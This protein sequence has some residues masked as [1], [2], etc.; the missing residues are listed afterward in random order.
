[1]AGGAGEK[2]ATGKYIQKF[3]PSKIEKEND[4]RLYFN[5]SDTIS[6]NNVNYNQFD[7][8]DTSKKH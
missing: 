8:K 6:C 4:F 3:Q 7:R 1:M 2:D 5:V